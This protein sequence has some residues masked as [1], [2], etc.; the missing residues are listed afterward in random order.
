L[1][2]EKDAEWDAFRNGAV[3]MSVAYTTSS[4]PPSLNEDADIKAHA[5]VLAS[6]NLG[7]VNPGGTV[8]RYVDFC[9]G[10]IPAMHRTQSLD[11]GILLEGTIEMLLDSGVVRTLRRGDIAV[12]RATM[13]AWRNPSK[14]EWARMVFV[15]QDCQPLTV[16]DGVLEEDIASVSGDVPPSHRET[17]L[18]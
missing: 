17:K 2:S 16:G 1:H 14:T 4:F 10:N 8:C 5:E 7:L 9:P 6:G 11:F 15:L 18:A 3:A 12:Q 13:H